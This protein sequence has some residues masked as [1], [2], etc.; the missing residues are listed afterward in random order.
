[1][2]S[3]PVPD[4]GTPDHRG[5]W[6]YLGWIARNQ[7]HVIVPGMF[8]GI[9]WMGSQ[10]FMPFVLG[11]A[12][13]DGLKA[14][15]A[16]ALVAWSLALLAL[17]LGQ[18]VAGM[19]RHRF[20]VQNWLSAAYRTIQVIVRK[21][22]A[23]GPTLPKRMTTGEVVSV[24]VADVAKI[25]D[26]MDIT[27]RGAGAI[28]SIIVVTA[29]LL[30]SMWQLGLV[31]LIGVPLILALTAP[32]MKP[33]HR[34]QTRQRELT[35]ELTTRAADI[36][37]GLRVLRG[38]GGEELFSTRFK[39]ES[40]SVRA[41]GVRT[42][43]VES[44]LDGVGL[45]LP[46]LLLVVVTWMG[47]RYAAAGTITVGQLFAFYGYA[48]FLVD[49]LWTIAEGADKITKAH[50]AAQ[51]IVKILSLKPEHPAT[52]TRAPDGQV[53]ADTVTGLEIRPGELT[54]VVAGTAAGELADRLGGYA[55][56]GSYGGVPLA[57]LDGLRERILVA[58]NEDRLFTGTVRGEIGGTA[59]AG[60]LAST[61]EEDP[62]PKL[63]RL[64]GTP[65][66]DVAP[67]PPQP[68][69]HDDER[70]LEAVWAAC[71]EDVVDAVGLDGL[72]AEGG[73]EFSGGQ[74][75]RVAMARALATEADVLVLVEPTSAVDAHTE[76][77]IADRIGKLRADR[78]TVVF[79]GSPLMLDKA[80][81][82]LFVADGKVV[83]EGDH[84]GLLRTCEAYRKAVT[85][86]E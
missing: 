34:R 69:V 20:A 85:R 23:L 50:V 21:A 14:K 29:V 68:H 63:G 31:V 52:G 33:L 53:L 48:A 58:I 32:L 37:G 10:A 41:A 24:G 65:P 77:R 35:G 40:Q 6:R 8:L 73:R 15:D 46:G 38:I 71:A 54:A 30:S 4:P 81:N 2:R 80:D 39:E 45:L 13:D 70:L 9:A 1:M 25:G 84:A 49:P 16:G 11:K 43:R 62:V 47:A 57:E 61:V 79:T 76:A 7:L 51:R 75:Q 82:V 55:D 60:L 28:V 86:D 42:A 66:P 72:V 3:L 78:T 74:R 5:P 22:T 26:A 67:A 59:P 19:F 64:W 17:G 36:V 12:I 83:A 18:T 44:V 27:A 56:G